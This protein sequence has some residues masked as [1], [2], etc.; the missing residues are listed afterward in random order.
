METGVVG[1][2]GRVPGGREE[3]A[4]RFET[5]MPVGRGGMGEV[6]RAWDPVLGRAVAL[7]F[8]RVDN[9]ELEERM[10]REARL[11]AR[12][13]HPN[14][15][16]IYEVGRDEGRIYIAMRF[17][18][19]TTLDRA[20]VGL[21]LDRR[22][23]LVKTVAEAVHAAH[24]VGLIHR[25]LKPANILV[26]DTDEGELKPWVVDFGVAR[27]KE[28][29]SATLTG[30][31]VGT[32]GYI[33]PE[34]AQG[35]VSSLDRR[36]DVFSLGV[37]LYELV[38]GAK[39]FGGD[40][41]LE[42]MLQLLEG[43]AIPLRRR[44]P[45]V[46]RELE[47]VIMKCLESERE[48]RYPSARALA[49][50]LGRFLA[51][52]PVLARPTGLLGRL[53]GRARRHPRAA[54]LL[55]AAALAVAG[56]AGALAASWVRYT[57]DLRR[58]RDAANAARAE[59]EARAREAAQVSEFLAGL[60]ASPNPQ[61]ARGKEFTARQLLDEGTARLEGELAGQPD[62]LARLLLVSSSSYQGLGLWA[63]AAHLAERALALHRQTSGDRSLAAADAMSALAQA[64]A[65]QRPAEAEQLLR[66]VVSI[67]RQQLGEEDPSVATARTSL[68][69]VLIRLERPEEAEQLIGEALAVLRA[70]LGEDARETLIAKERMA[71]LLRRRGEHAAAVAMYAEILAARRAR[72]GEE[73]PDLGAAYNNLA[74]AQRHAG[75][76]AGAEENYRRSLRLATTMLGPSHPDTLQV[77]SNLA[78]VLELAG[79]GEETLALLRQK[80][81]LRRA[82]VGI[83]DWRLASD[84]GLGVGRFL[85]LQGRYAEAEAPVRE[86]LEVFR[87]TLGEDHSWTALARG[88]LAACLFGLGKSREARPLAA[89]SL[90]RLELLEALP[91]HVRLE[92]QRNGAYLRAVGQEGLAARYEAIL[93]RLG[94]PDRAP[95][96]G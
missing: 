18:D 3:E 33:S 89:A 37:I 86:A 66:E 36:S 35:E 54:A 82:S 32:P 83:R 55:A 2:C 14:V 57:V 90:R 52:E 38:G 87:S 5:A 13:Q 10:L 75:D 71:S 70:R 45:H 60:F 80:A 96:A 9:P 15:C 44:A 43:E 24:Q 39:P 41:D 17:I 92:L 26:E 59:A 56:L 51:G 69:W 68:A 4:V 73:H 62:T 7:K 16:P 61:V 64:L 93:A 48:R 72:L 29:P 85:M 94:R 31:V 6:A 88:Q 50:D 47:T 53:R 58:E 20:A 23:E 25:D 30:Q 11:Q 84:L 12:V 67:R 63:E 49:E 1:P 77:M 27:E 19:G 79:R 8:L 40:S 78:G 81:E 28:V 95:A 22:V 21:S 65:Y 76:L 74:L 91:E 34:Q 46:P 42:A